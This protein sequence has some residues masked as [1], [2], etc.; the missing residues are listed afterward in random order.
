MLEGIP[1]SEAARPCSATE[2]CLAA[3]QKELD[4]LVESARKSGALAFATV[5]N[6]SGSVAGMAV[7]VNE[8]K[9]FYIRLSSGAAGAAEL[10]LKTIF[11]D[12]GIIKAGHGIKSQLGF[13]EKSGI[14]SNVGLAGFFDT[15]LAAYLLNP[16]RKNFSLD[17]IALEYLGFSGS[18]ASTGSELFDSCAEFASYCGSAD[19]VF[20]LKKMFSAQLEERKLA[21]LFY[22]VEM[23][24][25]E[26]LHKMEETGVLIDRAYFTSLSNEFSAEM[27]RK[28]DD[29][30][31]LAGERFNINSSKQLASI[32]FGK[33]EMKPV[34]KT[35]TGYSTDEEVLSILSSSHKLPEA[36]LGYREIAKLK[37]TFVDALLDRV[38]VSTGRLHTSFNQAGTVT[39]RL[40]SL[41][42]NL[43]NIPVKTES[44]RRIRRGFVPPEGFLLVSFD[45]SQIDLRML[46]HISGDPVLR[47]AFAE[48][49]DVHVSTAAEVFGV[50]REEVTPEMRKRAK[51]INFGIVYGQQAWGLSQQIGVS[52]DEARDYIDRYFLR[53][54]GVKKWID[55]TIAAAR[56]CGCVKTLLG[57]NR[58]LPDINSKN[59]QL[60]AFSERI[61]VNT[62]VQGTSADLIKVAMIN[63]SRRL[64]A[65][66]SASR[67]LI[68]VH[69]DLLFEISEL[70]MRETSVMIKSEMENALK[71]D[72]PVVADVKSGKNW[73][74]MYAT[75]I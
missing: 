20:R 54:G 69:D 40:S 10:A 29:I 2:S 12:A 1:G 4:E 36:I 63:I 38:D 16:A 24:L 44:G 32:L 11:R 8:G 35:K 7:C 47:Q 34:R 13:L 70:E 55:E 27:K 71:L 68:Q 26:V 25:A 48:G 73:A 57:R 43:Q 58:Y 23:P 50:K 59:N 33:L 5:L 15:E 21:K 51:G 42:P 62:P 72:V 66:G 56:E 74:D 49:T 18:R 31:S 75:K 60:R 53:Y 45:Y 64:A 22:D 17:E 39:G 30:Y 3:G 9:A 65:A 37:S 46:A 61:A 28:E 6:G 14:G 52:V 67:M 41:E 19:I